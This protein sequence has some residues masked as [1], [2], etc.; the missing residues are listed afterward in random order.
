MRVIQ[1][2]DDLRMLKSKNIKLDYTQKRYFDELFAN[3]TSKYEFNVDETKS[4]SKLLSSKG[5]T[6]KKLHE[7]SEFAKI[8]LKATENIMKTSHKTNYNYENYKI[9]EKYCLKPYSSTPCDAYYP[10]RSIDGSCNNLV[11]PWYGA[12]HTPFKRLL[13]ADYDDGLN[14]MKDKSVVNGYHLP[15]ARSVSLRI[16]KEY[17]T[18]SVWSNYAIS[19]GQN[20]AHDLSKTYGA[21]LSDGSKLKCKC[22]Q[23]NEHCFNIPIPKEDYFYGNYNDEKYSK[24]NDYY[25]M[26]CIPFTRDQASV[27]DYD[28]NYGPREQLNK[29]THFLDLSFIYSNNPH[30]R[31]R[32]GGLLSFSVNAKGEIIFPLIKGNNIGYGSGCPANL[33][34]KW[35]HTA[36]ED[37][38]QNIYLHSSQVIWLRN[39]N[40][41]AAALHKLNYH[42]DD[43][44][45]FQQARKINIAMFQHVVYNEYLPS[46]LGPKVLRMYDLE[47]LTW[48][49]YMK[50]DSELYPQ[51]LNEF[52]TAVFRQHFLVNHKHCYADKKFRKYGC[53]DLVEGLL[54]STSTCYSIDAVL[55]GQIA[56]YSYYSTPQ[57][58]WV[59]NNYL[60]RQKESIGTI[61]IQRGRDHG[62]RGYNFYRELCGLNRAKSF[63]ELYNIPP[64]VR[65]ELKKLYYHVDDIDLWTG[66]SAELPIPDGFLGHTFSCITAKQFLDLKKG[67]RFYYENGQSKVTRFT[68]EQLNFIRS[69]TLSSIICRNVEADVSPKWPFLA[70]DPKFNPMINCEKSLYSSYSSLNAWKDAKIYK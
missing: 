19:F 11:N 69:T 70:Y 24:D 33:N 55:R 50:Y 46:V 57:V 7:A 29:N 30:T 34:S 43:E 44:T 62:L 51:L 16:H 58:S 35:F 20:I 38:E 9:P 6:N 13:K 4:A 52:S 12:A 32:V 26:S 49:Y 28:C 45:L 23:P 39:H 2:Y 25:K 17:P 40:K 8:A 31:K 54:N 21:E 15:N 53:H 47:P 3:L 59:M 36:D 60:L 42:W 61:N 65:N 27:K 48:G 67:D 63:D 10:Y 18:K 56:D 14:Q 5:N 68:P 37:S 41:L 1:A 66:G 64:S 22:N